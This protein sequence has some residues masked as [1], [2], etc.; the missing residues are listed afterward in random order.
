MQNACGISIREIAKC[1]KCGQ[2]YQDRDSV[3]MVKKMQADGYAP[4]P[5]MQCSGEMEI[6][7]ESRQI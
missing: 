2:V 1:K 3:E 6:I 4:C 7:L 5:N